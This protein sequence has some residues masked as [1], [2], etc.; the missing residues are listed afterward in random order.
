MAL[1]DM[2]KYRHRE[3]PPEEIIEEIDDR[4]NSNA[5]LNAMEKPANE[6]SMREFI[7][8]SIAQGYSV[9]DYIA[10]NEEAEQILKST[11]L[12]ITALHEYPHV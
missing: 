11:D 2:N 3:I 5:V 9:N 6:M 8:T 7:A 12:L 1:F 10:T 4:I